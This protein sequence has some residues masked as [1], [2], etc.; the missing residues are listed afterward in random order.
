[1]DKSKRFQVTVW[2]L[3]KNKPGITPNS[4]PIKV[5]QGDPRPFGKQQG[6]Q[7]IHDHS[8][9]APN[10]LGHIAQQPGF[11]AYC[12]GAIAMTVKWVLGGM[13]EPCEVLARRMVEALPAPLAS[14]FREHGM[15]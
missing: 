3:W 10:R 6:G 1:M 8:H 15:L 12:N 11:E 9:D 5:N 14:L 13:K 2:P 7:Q 4:A